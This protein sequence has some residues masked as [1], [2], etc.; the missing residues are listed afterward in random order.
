ML[1]LASNLACSKFKAKQRLRQQLC[2]RPPHVLPLTVCMTGRNISSQCSLPKT[3]MPLKLEATPSKTSKGTEQEHNATD[4]RPVDGCKTDTEPARH[5]QG[6]SQCPQHTF[7]V[8]IFFFHLSCKSSSEQG[9][10]KTFFNLVTK[11]G[12]LVFL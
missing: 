11:L 8:L 5:G 7:K 9:R 4:A 3:S 6:T 2:I 10:H 12:P 1:N